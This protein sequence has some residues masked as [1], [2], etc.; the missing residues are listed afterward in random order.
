MADL[1]FSSLYDSFSN[2]DFSLLSTVTDNA[3]IAYHTVLDGRDT[4]GTKAYPTEITNPAAVHNDTVYGF[5]GLVELA[6]QEDVF[7]V[8][9]DSSATDYYLSGYE[10]KN[11]SNYTMNDAKAAFTLPPFQDLTWSFAYTSAE[12][13]ALTYYNQN[14]NAN[15]IAD[16]SNNDLVR[17]Y[18]YPDATS[19]YI[20]NWMLAIDWLKLPSNVG[21]A[22]V[23]ATDF[24]FNA[25]YFDLYIT[26]PND[27]LLTTEGDVDL[28]E[29]LKDI[30]DVNITKVD[31]SSDSIIA[32]DENGQTL[33]NLY[34]Y[35]VRI[36]SPEDTAAVLNTLYA[37]GSDALAAIGLDSSNAANVDTT[38]A[39]ATN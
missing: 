2:D 33:D 21:S 24:D 4:N 26:S 30:K 22:Q 35:K 14:I 1:D 6:I 31:M 5:H 39:N 8:H 20:P 12:N 17:E 29:V 25:G 23:A 10:C 32:V 38:D 34:V 3:D 27:N 28:R 11:D 9:C 37:L 7:T 18:F 15:W 13:A 36:I 19:I 16:L